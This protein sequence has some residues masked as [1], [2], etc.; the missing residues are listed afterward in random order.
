MNCQSLRSNTPRLLASDD[1]Q[2]GR[3]QFQKTVVQD[4]RLM[5]DGH[6]GGGIAAEARGGHASD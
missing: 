2:S 1:V 4:E 5:I 3:M 6:A